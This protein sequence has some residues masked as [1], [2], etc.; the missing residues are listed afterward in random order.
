M[1]GSFIMFNKNIYCNVLPL[2][3]LTIKYF[4]Y[5]ILI[6][7]DYIDN[8]SNPYDVPQE[9]YNK[10]QSIITNN[11]QVDAN[12]LKLMWKDIF[13]FCHKGATLSHIQAMSEVAFSLQSISKIDVQESDWDAIHD[14]AGQLEV[15]ATMDEALELINSIKNELIRL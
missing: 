6:M 15:A 3:M 1:D 10:Y 4:E 7:K 9:F 11:S 5:N 13:E 8:Q 2:D 14:Y 12:T